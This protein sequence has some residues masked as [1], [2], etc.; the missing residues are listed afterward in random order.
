MN[1]STYCTLRNENFLG[2]IS[3]GR[4]IWQ[5]RLGRLRRSEQY[6]NCVRQLPFSRA[7][8]DI[9][10]TIKQYVIQLDVTCTRH[11][12]IQIATDKR[13]IRPIFVAVTFYWSSYFLVFSTRNEKWIFLRPENDNTLEE[14]AK[15]QSNKCTNC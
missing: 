4:K 6:H 13:A 5:K 15:K 9:M 12:K 10:L 14:E 7:N 3:H 8:N 2:R 11:W 1:H